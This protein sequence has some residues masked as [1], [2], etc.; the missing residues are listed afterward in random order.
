M[1]ENIKVEVALEIISMYIAIA[2]QENDLDKMKTLNYE[3]E[4]IYKQNK[5][6]IEKVISEY[7]KIVEKKL[8]D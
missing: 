8:E 7:G 2:K 1:K 3:R 6:I 5:Y 4:E